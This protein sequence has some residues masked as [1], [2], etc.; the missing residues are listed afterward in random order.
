MQVIPPRHPVN[1][2]KRD[3]MSIKVYPV[4]CDECYELCAYSNQ[5]MDDDSQP[6]I[7]C[8]KCYIKNDKYS[9]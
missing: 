6:M 1:Q 9:E 4:E 2:P 5:N 3:I 7:I 8:L